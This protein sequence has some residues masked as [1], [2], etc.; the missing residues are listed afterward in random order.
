MARNGAGAR[1]ELMATELLDQAAALFAERGYSG[2]TLQDI[3]E[4]M[5]LSRPALYR[6]VSN[7]EELLAELVAGVSKDAARALAAIRERDDLDEIGRLEAAVRD[8]ALRT[9]HNPLRFRVLVLSEADLPASV[10]P[11]HR[12]AKRAVLDHLVAMVD[13]AMRAGALRAVDEH[14]AVFFLLGAV[15]WVAWWYEPG[16]RLSPE[17]LADAMVALAL[18]GLRRPGREGG[19]GGVTAVLADL[20]ED[21]ALLGRLLGEDGRRGP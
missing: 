12:R 20:R 8:M 19:Q 14:V 13:D 1:R 16:G 11:A 2:T 3:A 15:N 21:V 6:Y 7:K 18:D 17:Q 10:A 9:A 4:A 5:G